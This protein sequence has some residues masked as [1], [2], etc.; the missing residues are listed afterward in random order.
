MPARKIGLEEAK[1]LIEDRINE[2]KRSEKYDDWME[3]LRED[4]FID[5]RI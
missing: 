1:P 2:I 4:S 3:K 5:I